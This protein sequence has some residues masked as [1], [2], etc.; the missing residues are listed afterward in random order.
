MKRFQ[1]THLTGEE[2]ET[3]LNDIDMS[4]TTFARLVGADIRR[5]DRWYA[6][7][8]EIPHYVA[9][10]LQL[11]KIPGAKGIARMVAAAMI[12]RDNEHPERGEYPYM[13]GR[14]LPEDFIAPDTED[15]HDEENA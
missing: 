6:G 13:D 3:A 2:F 5:V 15:E 10:V 1:Y 8:Y 9:L 4:T 14:D 12:E 11:L 7:K